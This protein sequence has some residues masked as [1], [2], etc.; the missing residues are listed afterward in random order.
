[1]KIIINKRKLL[2][3][4]LIIL[5]LLIASSIL[6]YFFFLRERQTTAY[7]RL[8]EHCTEEEQGVKKCD[9][10]LSDYTQEDGNT[11]MSI[12]LPEIDPSLR[13]IEIEFNKEVKWTN[14]Y[15]DYSL[16]IPVVLNMYYSNRLFNKN[17]PDRIEIELMEDEEVYKILEQINFSSDE[18]IEARTT[19]ANEILTR[20]YNYY[21]HSPWGDEEEYLVWALVNVRFESIKISQ[22]KKEFSISFEMEDTGYNYSF[23]AD[24]IVFVTS[25]TGKVIKL[26]STSEINENLNINDRYAIAFSIFKSRNDERVYTYYEGLKDDIHNYFHGSSDSGIYLKLEEIIK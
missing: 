17:L 25:K 23:L 12:V 21:P 22:D 9:V 20:G 24:E 13:D 16:D 18:V 2:I 5:G 7:D 19:V 10:F 15:E 4:L 6:I 8:L 3:S 1:M 14:P 26:K 11:L